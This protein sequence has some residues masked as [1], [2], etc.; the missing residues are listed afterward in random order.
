MIGEFDSASS[1]RRCRAGH[2]ITADFSRA[3]QRFAGFDAGV[4]SVLEHLLAIH[5]NVSYTD[6]VLVWVFESRAVANCLRVENNYVGK[7]ALLEQS[8]MIEAKI[9][10]R[11]ARQ[12]PHSFRE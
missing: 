12:S 8:A 4:L 10:C 7:H 3:P 5:K 9:S 11:Q 2:L 6:R 1:L